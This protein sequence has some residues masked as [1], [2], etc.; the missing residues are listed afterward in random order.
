MN[1][2]IKIKIFGKGFEILFLGR[3]IQEKAGCLNLTWYFI[4]MGLLTRGTLLLRIL[5]SWYHIYIYINIY[6]YLIFIIDWL[7]I[8]VSAMTKTYTRDR[9][10]LQWV[11]FSMHFLA[12]IF[13]GGAPT[14]TCGFFCQSVSPSVIIIW[15]GPGFQAMRIIEA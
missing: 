10:D 6:L 14:S 8:F 12:V 1:K 4:L 5:V 11:L 15:S 3:M 13:L 2:N 7:C 9:K